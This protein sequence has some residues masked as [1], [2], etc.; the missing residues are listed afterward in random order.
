[1]GDTQEELQFTPSPI[2]TD[3]PKEQPVDMQAMVNK[4]AAIA[5]VPKED[6][7]ANLDLMGASLSAAMN[8]EINVRDA[9]IAVS[10][11]GG[12]KAIR[13]LAATLRVRDLQ[14]GK[15][16]FYKAASDANLAQA[17]M[18]AR[19]IERVAKTDVS[20]DTAKAT[21]SV[22]KEAATNATASPETV[23]QNTMDHLARVVEQKGSETGI[24]E[25]VAQA[26]TSKFGGSI[27]GLGTGLEILGGAVGIPAVAAYALGGIAGGI[28][29]VGVGSTFS[30]ESVVKTN[31]AIEAVTGIKS[32]SAFGTAEQMVVLRTF[33]GTNLSLNKYVL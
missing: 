29:G 30:Y 14:E 3:L 17:E 28:A 25:V 33:L 16:A 4:N 11:G 26:I 32:P 7:V 6:N 22:V 19:H 24:A 9:T 27:P 5:G 8:G 20:N 23:R 18:Q 12:A 13:D 21:M 15:D 10:T 1:M 2:P 31:K